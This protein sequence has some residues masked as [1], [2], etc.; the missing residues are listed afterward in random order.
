[1]MSR[2]FFATI[3]LAALVT[4]PAMAADLARPAPVPYK[5]PP[6]AVYVYNWTGCYVGGHAGGL[7]ATKDWYDDDPRNLNGTF[8]QFDGRHNPNGFLGGIQA[9]CDYQFAGGF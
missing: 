7:W 3:A 6:P 5:A 8:G 9:G 1:M 2:T 4:A